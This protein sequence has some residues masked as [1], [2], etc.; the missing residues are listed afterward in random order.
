MG[1]RNNGQF[2][3][4]YEFAQRQNLVLDDYGVSFVINTDIWLV[5]LGCLSTLIMMKSVT[6][7]VLADVQS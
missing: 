6:E 2:N 5:S 7:N 3:S 4:S 1:R